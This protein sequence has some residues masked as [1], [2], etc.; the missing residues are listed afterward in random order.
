M[1]PRG[2]SISPLPRRGT[3][4]AAILL[5]TLV[6]ALAVVVALGGCTKVPPPEETMKALGAKLGSAKLDQTDFKSLIPQYTTEAYRGNVQPEQADYQLFLAGKAADQALNKG[7]S[8]AL[9]VKQDVSGDKAEFTFDVGKA[10]GIF[11]VAG[12][13]TIGVTLAKTGE[14]AQPWRIEAIRLTQ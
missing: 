4:R 8:T 14:D 11:D 3:R 13:S 5:L 9:P 2:A 12:F 1:T 7:D 10:G 6:S